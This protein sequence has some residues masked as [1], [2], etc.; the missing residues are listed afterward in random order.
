MCHRCKSLRSHCALYIYCTFKQVHK[1]F[2]L[3]I[4]LHCSFRIFGY[5]IS[6]LGLASAWAAWS[7]WTCSHCGNGTL[8]RQRIC[9][10]ACNDTCTINSTVTEQGSSCWGGEFC[11]M[12]RLKLLS[13]VAWFIYY[14]YIPHPILAFLFQLFQSIL[15]PVFTLVLH[16]YKRILPSGCTQGPRFIGA[17]GM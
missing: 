13:S 5:E 11:L 2:D 9:E 8:L 1:N 17:A 15:I 3:R 4:Y 10:G 14:Y 16:T 7:A 12:N 6:P